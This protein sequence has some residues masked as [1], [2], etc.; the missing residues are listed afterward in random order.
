MN[1]SHWNEFVEALRFLYEQW[2]NICRHRHSNFDFEIN[3]FRFN[4]S[5]VS[6]KISSI[7]MSRILGINK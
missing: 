2:V 6:G 1:K 4:F 7:N 5:P 3:I